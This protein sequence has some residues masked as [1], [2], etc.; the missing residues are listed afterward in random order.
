[1]VV[2][3]FAGPSGGTQHA[4]SQHLLLNPVSNVVMVSGAGECPGKALG[5]QR[6]ELF[7]Y[8]LDGGHA[9]GVHF[10]KRGQGWL[11]TDWTLQ[12]VSSWHIDVRWSGGGTLSGPR[13]RASSVGKWRA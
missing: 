3:L 10:L 5:P 12:V 13:G 1:M 7:W 6:S 9:F 2:V 8:V 4:L 11:L